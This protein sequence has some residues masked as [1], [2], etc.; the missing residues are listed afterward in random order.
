VSTGELFVAK[1]FDPLVIGNLTL[2]NRIVMPP[3]AND[4]AD[5]EGRVTDRLIA[6]YTRRAPGVG[7]VIV[8]HSYFTPEGKASSNQLGIH[9]DAMIN[10]LTKLTE[11]I[12]AKETPVCIQVNH[13]GREGSSAISG[14]EPVAPSVV[15]TD[16]SGVIPR[17][18]ERHEI[19]HLVRLFGKAARRARKAG[20]DAVEVHGAHGYLLNQFTSPLTNRRTGEYGGS[21]EGRIRFPLEIVAEVRKAV[22]SD[23]L[24]LY[25]LGA[26]DGEGRGVTIGE[27]QTFAQRLVRAGINIVDVSGGLIGDAPEGMTAQGYFLPLAEKI[28]QAVEA[29]V[30]GVGGIT[31]PAFADQAIR[32]GRVDLVAVGRA[33]LADPDW[34]LSAK[35]TLGHET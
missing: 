23:F 9:D 16:S 30:I 32:Q 31:D 27:S 12:H 2:K 22:G 29:P 20:F 7:L 18:L 25:R 5:T 35:R 14:V 4:L 8:E 19:Q 3:M 13:P 15:P 21:F 10:G 28:K 17:E 11:S 1:L 33:L 24:V 34:A 6:H 26:S